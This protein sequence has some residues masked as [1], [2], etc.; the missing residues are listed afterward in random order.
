M[1]G[2]GTRWWLGLAALAGVG[3]CATSCASR[4][5]PPVTTVPAV[6]L[7]RYAGTWYELGRFPNRFERGLV[8]VTATYTPRADGTIGVRNAGRD[9]R[10][11]GPEKSVEGHAWLPD[12]ADTAK[13]RVRFFWPFYGAYWIIALDADYRWAV[14][15]HPDRD[16]LWF[17]SRTPQIEDEDWAAMDAAAQ[18]QGFDTTRLERIPQPE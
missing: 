6:D 7:A 14:V 15:G 16:Y 9:R 11:D 17:L 13:L 10:V 3:A 12:P 1:A 18:E 4:V 5:A 8:A 2:R